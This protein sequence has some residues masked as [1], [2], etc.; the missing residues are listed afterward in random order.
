MSTARR[1]QIP[2]L[3]LWN[4]E[5]IMDQFLLTALTFL[6][7]LVRPDLSADQV[8]FAIKRI[9]D[10]YGEYKDPEVLYRELNKVLAEIL[11]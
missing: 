5:T 10:L 2:Q 1:L 7:G 9:E 4:G 3:S 8:A 6:V 11:T